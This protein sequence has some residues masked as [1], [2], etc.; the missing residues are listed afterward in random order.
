MKAS[1]LSMV[2]LL[3]VSL[4]MAGLPAVA[5]TPDGSTPAEETVCD[6]LMDEVVTPGLYGLCLA[7]CE[8]QDIASEDMALTDDEILALLNDVPSGSILQTYNQLRKESDPEM[9]CIVRA[10]EP[11]SCPCWTAEEL[12]EIDTPANTPN[13]TSRTL[14]RFVVD[15]QTGLVDTTIAFEIDT[16]ID[17]A[18]ITAIAANQERFG[19]PTPTRNCEFQNL[20]VDPIIDRDI[21]NLSSG[22][23]AF[24]LDEL[25]THCDSLGFPPP[26]E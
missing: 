3:F 12:A 8:A 5:S 25:I 19:M 13:G 26:S 11:S 10:P 15:S 22:E 2:G 6:P 17:R 18:T 14:C 7:F 1:R 23:A 24:C 20:Q 21:S 4:A 16:T 9:P